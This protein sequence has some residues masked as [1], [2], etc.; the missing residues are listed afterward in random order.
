MSSSEGISAEALAI[1]GRSSN[2]KGKGDRGRSKSRPGFRD[3]K[4]QCAF[5]K[6]LR[7]WMINCS[8]AKG[9]KKESKTK[10]NLAQVISTQASTSQVDGSDSNSSV[11]SFSVTTS[12]VGYSSNSEWVLDIEATYHVCS[13][14]NWFSSFE[15]LDG[16]FTIMGDDYPCNPYQDG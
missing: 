3:L 11:F 14:M 12:N 2:R 7:H 10:I 8:K 9:E 5:C 15:K 6:E 16:C 13:N 4:N 1:R